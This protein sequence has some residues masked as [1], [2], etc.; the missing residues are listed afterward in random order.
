MHFQDLPGV[1]MLRERT[2]GVPQHVIAAKLGCT[3]A[4]ISYV[5]A[6]KQR[7]GVA[8]RAKARESYGVPVEAWLTAD[9][10]PPDDAN[11]ASHLETPQAARTSSIPPSRQ[12]LDAA[13]SEGCPA[14]SEAA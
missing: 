4:F 12:P 7:L 2:V 9:E 10:L 13:A 11:D 1:V 6:G 14:P 3:Q 5:L 8:Y